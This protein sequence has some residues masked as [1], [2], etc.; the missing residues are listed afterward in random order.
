MTLNRQV[1]NINIGGF[2][3]G[4]AQSV[5]VSLS[6]STLTVNVDGHS[7]SVTLP[8]SDAASISGSIII[9]ELSVNYEST[10]TSASRASVECRDIDLAGDVTVSCPN[11]IVRTYNRSSSNTNKVTK[12][13]SGLACNINGS[14]T[15]KIT[16]CF[17]ATYASDISSVYLTST[18]AMGYIL[19][20]FDKGNLVSSKPY[21]LFG[22]SGYFAVYGVAIS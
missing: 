8:T 6:G 15:V 12:I 11:V 1:G 13:K 17:S 7:D 19:C 2:S 16:G 3:S 10:V 22:V 4:G 14:G 18:G 21:N 20:V 9:N 5:N